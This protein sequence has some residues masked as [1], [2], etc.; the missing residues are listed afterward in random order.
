[1]LLTFSVF[2]WLSLRQLQTTEPHASGRYCGKRV[3]SG[4]SSAISTFGSQGFAR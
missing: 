2:A 3:V 1:L 4:T